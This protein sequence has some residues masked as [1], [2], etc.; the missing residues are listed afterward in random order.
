MV[1]SQNVTPQL[2]S[3]FV[4][5]VNSQTKAQSTDQTKENKRRREKYLDTDKAQSLAHRNKT[6]GKQIPTKTHSVVFTVP[7]NETD[8]ETD[9]ETD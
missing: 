1:A 4:F 9:S 3:N 6:P 5:Q 8:S 7:E 2:I